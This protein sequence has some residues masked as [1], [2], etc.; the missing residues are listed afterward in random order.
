MQDW[1]SAFICRRLPDDWLELSLTMA[2]FFA[3]VLGLYVGLIDSWR[4]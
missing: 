1:W 2:I 4:F 3:L